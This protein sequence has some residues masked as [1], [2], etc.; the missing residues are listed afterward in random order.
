MTQDRG[1]TTRWLMLMV[2]F[3]SAF[4]IVGAWNRTDSMSHFPIEQQSKFSS[5]ATTY[6][7]T[8]GIQTIT[9]PAGM[10]YMLVTLYGASGGT[11]GS[12][13]GGY[14]G[15]ISAI[16]EEAWRSAATERAVAVRL[17]CVC[18]RTA[19]PTASSLPAGAV[20]P[21]VTV[22]PLVETPAIPA[23]FKHLCA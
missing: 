8:G 11:W 21:L 18:L 14:G 13:P 2:F 12:A 15:M 7:Y 22:R 6:G 17:T 3:I 16:T 9:V 5:M 20:V 4:T 10:G 19:Q 23:E 1:K